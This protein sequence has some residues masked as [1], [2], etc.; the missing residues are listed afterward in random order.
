MTNALRH[1]SV[2]ALLLG[3]LCHLNSQTFEERL[4]AA[5]AVLDEDNKCEA[6][7][8]AENLTEDIKKSLAEKPD[9]PRLNFVY[10]SICM[11]GGFD[12][13]AAK[14]LDKAIAVALQNVDYLIL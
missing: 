6:R 8:K 2:A 7:P 14:P 3:L 4:A 11:D 13:D 12:D 1:L 10:G 9:E 5:R